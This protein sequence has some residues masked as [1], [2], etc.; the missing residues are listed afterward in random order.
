MSDDTNYKQNN[1]D[2]GK[3]LVTRDY[4]NRVY[5]S[6]DT[7]YRRNVLW[8]WGSIPP[9]LSANATATVL[10]EPYQVLPLSTCS[11]YPSGWRD[12][13]ISSSCS[14]EINVRLLDQQGKM[15]VWGALSGAGVSWPSGSGV[16]GYN[17]P[18][19]LC[20]TAIIEAC[21]VYNCIQKLG[22]DHSDCHVSYSTQSSTY[23][24]G[25]AAGGL[26]GTCCTLSVGTINQTYQW[27]PYNTFSDVPYISIQN[28]VCVG[29]YPGH[30]E[31]GLLYYWGTNSVSG[32]RSHPV[33]TTGLC[34]KCVCSNGATV[35]GLDPNN[36]V[37][38][39]MG[40]NDKGQLGSSTTINRVGYSLTSCFSNTNPSLAVKSYSIGR[41]S[42]FA[43]ASNGTLWAWGDNAY[44]QLGNNRTVNT[45][46]PV[47]SID[48]NNDWKYVTSNKMGTAVA[49]LKNDGS[50]WVW[51]DSGYIDGIGNVAVRRS[52]PVQVGNRKNW[53]KI[54]VENCRGD[55]L[56]PGTNFMVG[57]TEEDL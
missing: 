28:Q 44:G 5:T 30:A 22:R 54:A 4:F 32:N 53:L 42:S 8:A 12:F 16:S 7:S 18:S 45:S 50:L 19:A 25:C 43:V 3:C 57:I 14:G 49:A 13:H 40:Y 47:Q 37:L 31:A 48:T 9:D 41:C 51:G 11:F 23:V 27:P 2:I 24:W 52:S 26:L 20:T 38:K 34:L 21:T 33:F 17:R 1:I 15:Y 36:N 10:A 46:C 35:G 39:I 55:A 6:V 29:I 56:V